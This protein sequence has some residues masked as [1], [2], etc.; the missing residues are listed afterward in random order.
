MARAEL[1]TIR[2]RNGENNLEAGDFSPQY[3][4]ALMEGVRTFIWLCASLGVYLS[5][6][7]LSAAQYAELL[8]QCW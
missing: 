8:V 1:R 3:M 2:E 5:E 4:A 6:I 7:E